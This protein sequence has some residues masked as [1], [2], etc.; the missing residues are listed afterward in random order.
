MKMGRHI[1]GY[2]KELKL[3]R[4]GKENE[5]QKTFPI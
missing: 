3:V 4:G 1:Y 2:A 5:L